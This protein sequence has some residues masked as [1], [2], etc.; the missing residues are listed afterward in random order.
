MKTHLVLNDFLATFLYFRL[1]SFKNWLKR[2]PNFE[3]YMYII[4]GR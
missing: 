2:K 4:T 3:L 1:L